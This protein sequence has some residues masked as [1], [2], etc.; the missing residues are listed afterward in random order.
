MAI[1]VQGNIVID[2]SQNI[3]NIGVATIGSID[4]NKISPDGTDF[5]ALSYIPVADGSGTWSWQPITSAGGGTLDG[6]TVQEETSTVGTAG[7]I[8]TLKF[9]GNNITAT[10][11][12]GGA[13]ATITAS[14]TP[15]FD[16]LGIGTRIDLIPYDTLDNGTLSFEG[17]AGQLFSITN[18]LSSGSIF[19]VNDV[20]GIPSIDV[21]AD[22]TIQLAPY[23]STE[24]VGIGTTN[25]TAKLDVNGTLNVSGSS[26]F[27]S[28]VHLLDDDELLIGGSAGTHDG[29]KIYHSTSGTE[30][31]YIQDT[32]N[33][34]LYIDGYSSINL[35]RYS[36]GDSLASF[37]AGGAVN[38]YYDG[39][40]KFE[41][42][43]DGILV[44]P[45]VGL[46]TTAG[47]A[48][49][50]QDLAEF[51]TSNSNS[52]KLRI[53]EARDVNG[54]DWTSAYTRIQKTIDST[55]MGYIQ[56]NGSDNNYG[57]EFGTYADGKFAQFIR[58]GSVDLYYDN[59]KK[60]ETTGIGVS[61]V[62]TGNT[63]TI[64]GPSN[65]VLDPAAVGD[66]TGTVTI[67]GNLQVDGT[68]T[69]I[70]STT[71]EVDDKLVSIAKSA[72]NATQ[73]D[74][75]G[76]EIN[77]ASATLTY[78]STSDSWVFN[79]APYYNTNRILTTADEGTGNGLDADT[80]DG[81]QKNTLVA[82]LRANHNITGGGTI[83]FNSSGY[84]KN[85]QRFIVISNGRGSHF[86][87]AGYFD[88]NIPTSGTITGVG[89]AT[90]V[91]ATS[92]G[93]PLAAWEALYYIL[94]IGSGNGSVAANFRVCKYTSDL[95]IPETWVLL[96]IRNGD[97]GQKCWVIG[98][99]GLELDESIDTATY[100]AK[101][102]D[103]VD[104]LEATS[105]LRS[106]A[107]DT[108]TG[109]IQITKANSTST[110]GGQLYLNGTTGNR[111]DFNQ[112]GVAAPAFTTRSVGTKLVLY[113]NIGA[114][115]VDFALGIENSTLWYSIDL[116]SSTKQ[117][118]WYAGTTKL[119]D[120][121]GSGEL[122]IGS[123][124]LTG[125]ASQKLQ[126]SGGAYVSGNLGIGVTNPDGKLHISSG[127]SGDCRVYIEAD[128]DNNAEGDN[129]F[130]IFKLDGGSE[131]SSVWT[132]NADGGSNDNSLNL[133]NSTSVGGGIRFFTNTTDSGWESAPER[134]RIT[135]SG[136]IGINTTAP[137]STLA[138]GGTI[139]ELYNGIYWNV[140]TQADVGYGAS[141]V[142]LNQY[143][144]Q[145]AFLDDYHPNGLRRD[146]GGSDDV[147]VGAGGSV[148]IGTINPT[149]QLHIEGDTLVNGNLYLNDTNYLSSLPTGDYGSVQID[150]SGKGGWEGYSI[151]G[152]SVFMED[153]SSTGAFG[154]FD[155]VNNHWAIRHQ[156]VNANDSYTEL[157]GGNN[158]TNLA[159]YG[160]DVRVLNVPLIVNRTTLTGTA[161]QNLQ[162]DG[163]A[164]VS[165]NLGVGVTNP[166]SR[167]EIYESTGTDLRLNTAVDKDNSITFAE[168]GI[169]YFR[170]L[171]DGSGLSSPNNVFKIQT[172]TVSTGINNDAITIKQSGDVGI[173]TDN[174][175]GPLHIDAPD[176]YLSI[177]A[178]GTNDFTGLRLRDNNS[179][180]GWLGLA[181]VVNHF[182]NGSA[183]GDIVLRAENNLLFAAGG[184]T[185]RIYVKSDG[186]IGIGTVTPGY[187]LE[188]NGSFA[189]TTKSFVIDHPTKEGM[190][191]R[192]GSLEGPE[193]G[194]Y[195]RG[196][197]KDNNTIELPDHW[198]G[199]VDEET[200]T[201]N[202]T[203]IGRKAPLHSVVD[204]VDN[205]V[206][207]ESANDVVDCFYT[208]FGERKD[209]EKLEV[210][211]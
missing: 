29:L 110:G 18:N 209:V 71:L 76:L 170:I 121:K 124:S 186:N 36:N 192:Y 141:Q 66:N 134:M 153:G 17:S 5:G 37:N 166:E 92:N 58:N 156:R 195:V 130:I 119:A 40:K 98:K 127:T 167:L 9:V 198:T 55:D 151:D 74:G 111:I 138:V 44:R 122:V 199:L 171:H 187:K 10:A 142:P 116:A 150:G 107:D 19:S 132:G 33:G 113:P 125:T 95:E 203:P 123:T 25:P 48:D 1:K 175:S 32:G 53:V 100:D 65:L 173:G 94:P 155:D 137:G 158:S 184:N 182:S 88:I 60:F 193:N 72:T 146:G 89:G 21:D 157:R 188:V 206:V 164:Y 43:A 85:S 135:T 115:Q 114:S 174:P 161:S 189:A 147:V 149:K 49:A 51:T 169:N 163:G 41:T 117:H 204:I 177:N 67:L 8:T 82:S 93:I 42:T 79:K 109:Q 160:T 2:D 183:N 136:N 15:T 52:S 39:T 86:S 23:G 35:R 196:R 181:G 108:T 152:L 91:S 172:G 28:N 105:F 64:T 27:Q 128:T 77:G 87:T 78:S 208:V 59:S 4:V 80:L 57:M 14:D 179:D 140:V 22:G 81:S 75:A 144:G 56:F 102:A 83:T 20:S 118:R 200:I 197:L 168:D 54:S 131:T 38:L 26:T 16:T 68:Q 84:L 133:A 154:L 69:I 61:I 207:V 202:L 104:G 24:Y 90:N 190:K 194:V 176:G 30:A 6:I 103:T 45:N 139:T 120:L 47:N 148:G 96:A 97:S 210:E 63:A 46:G 178:S 185:T 180:R 145:L 129:A 73:A 205:T 126:V 211:F 165:D 3:I 112:N 106:D 12:A 50:T 13:I 99:Y 159:V 31:S 191:L 162:V 101:N 11:V 62:G 34:V 7:S 201:V 143:L 70:N